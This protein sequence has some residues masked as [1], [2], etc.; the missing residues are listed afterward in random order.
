M[1]RPVHPSWHLI[2]P[3]M[4]VLLAVLLPGCGREDAPAN[5]PKVNPLQAELDRANQ[6]M[7]T[8]EKALDAK[9]EELNQARAAL[10]AAKTQIAEKDVVVAQRDT[11]MRALQSEIEKIKKSEAFVFAEISAAQQQG[12]SLIAS[13][14][15]EQFIKDFPRSPLAAN[16]ASAIAEI[17][18]TRQRDARVMAELADPKRRERELLQQ[19][20]DG[21]MT[22]QELAPILKKKTIAQ[23][24]A[25]LGQPNQTFNEGTE[26][27][28]ADKA[29]NPLTGKRGMFIVSFDSGVVATL[30]VEYAGRRLVP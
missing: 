26:L 27:G 19:F 5:T 13:G 14:R 10:E 9:I 28:Y 12:Q 3:L 29:I 16:A 4:L 23:V 20:N 24:V 11:Q 17:A 7:E 15:Y 22:L 2:V 18:A 1:A 25:L 21:F 8:S 30:R 6:R